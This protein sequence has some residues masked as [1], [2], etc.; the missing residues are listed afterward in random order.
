MVGRLIL[1]QVDVGSNPTPRTRTANVEVSIDWK[2]YAGNVEIR[3]WSR[4][5]MTRDKIMLW[6]NILGPET[7]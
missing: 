5:Y 3:W 4:G 7:I 6:V 2:T 1:D